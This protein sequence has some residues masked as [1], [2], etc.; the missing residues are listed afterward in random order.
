[1]Q[2]EDEILGLKKRLQIY[3]RMCSDYRSLL[4]RAQMTGILP[5]GLYRDIEM[6]LKAEEVW[7]KT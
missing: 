6:T 7:K 1:M 5:E 4:V 2:I 3:A